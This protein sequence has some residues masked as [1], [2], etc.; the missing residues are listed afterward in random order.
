MRNDKDRYSDFPVAAASIETKDC[1][2]NDVEDRPTTR[3]YRTY[4]KGD[5]DK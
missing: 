3:V 2:I 4:T 5:K 1:D